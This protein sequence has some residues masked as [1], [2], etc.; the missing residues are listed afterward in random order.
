M[1]I[2]ILRYYYYSFFL[3]SMRIALR[4]QKE[5]SAVYQGIPFDEKRDHQFAF[6]MNIILLFSDRSLK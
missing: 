6:T 5:K 2:F 4:D 3:Q 1:T